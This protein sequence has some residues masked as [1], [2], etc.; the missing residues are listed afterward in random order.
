[1]TD[2]L[3]VAFE[4]L[5]GAG[6]TTQAR[7][8]AAFVADETDRSPARSAEPTDGPVGTQI[9]RCLEGE[10]EFDPETLALLFA[11]DRLDHLHREIE[12]RLEAGDVVLVDRYS[13]SSFAYQRADGVDADWLRT[14]NARARPPD[15]TVFLDVPPA[16][17]VERITADGRGADRFERVE[18]LEAVDAAYREAIDAER[19]AGNDVRVV[20]GTQSENAVADEVTATIERFL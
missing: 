20:D 13:L 3:F 12:P 19:E 2:G 9:R 7:R 11:A 1:M 8:A 17:C 5:D 6:T 14:I 18:T 16:V 15:V 10:I 4:G